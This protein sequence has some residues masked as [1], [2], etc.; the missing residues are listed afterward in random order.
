MTTALKSK[1]EKTESEPKPIAD[2][3]EAAALRA[4]LLAHDE[5]IERRVAEEATTALKRA[6]AHEERRISQRTGAY[7]N[8]TRQN[9]ECFILDQ[10][11][12]QK[13]QVVSMARFARESVWRELQQRLEFDSRIAVAKQN[14]AS[15][16]RGML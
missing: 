16:G 15:T 6:Q 8:I 5:E 2:S 9:A 1:T 11:V 4:K 10:E 12:A 14:M 7:G 3:R 13:Q